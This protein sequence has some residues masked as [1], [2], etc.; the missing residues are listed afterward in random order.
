MKNS[1]IIFFILFIFSN[2]QICFG[3]EN[4]KEELK[5]LA[6]LNLKG[7]V[8]T[9]IEKS[10]NAKKNGVN[11][12]KTFEGW[13]SSWQKNNEQKFDVNGNLIDKTYFENSKPIR[14]DFFKYENNK[15]T[16]TNTLYANR[17]FTYD[18]FGKIKSEKFIDKKPKKITT[19]KENI[20]IKK[21]THI[22]YFYSE[23][24]K[25]IQKIESNLSGN[26][27]SVQNFKYDQNNN[28]IYQ[29]LKYSSRKE[30]YDYHYNNDNL[31]FKIEWK[32]DKFGLLEETFI[33]YNNH[34]K[35][36]E[37]WTNYFEGEK[38]GSIEYNYEKGNEI[39]TKE[40]DADG[41]LENAEKISYTYDK[42][43]NWINKTITL[44]SKAYIIERQIL[45]Y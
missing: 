9:I 11:Y 1:K 19:G 16:E 31:L 18:E 45:Y 27:V 2:F 37:N 41:N 20:P 15:I 30:W 35:K 25:L 4:P 36:T 24:S 39:Q 44:K 26:Q 22:E 32:D 38:E 14:N 29:E 10:F 40:F 21:E 8:K 3:Q 43:G 17:F 6:T 12:I 5:N 42:F 23:N 7:K 33:T 34:E 28:L 13:Q